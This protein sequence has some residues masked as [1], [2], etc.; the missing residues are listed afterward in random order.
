MYAKILHVSTKDLRICAKNPT[1]DYN[2]KL[3]LSNSGCFAPCAKT[4]GME[5]VYTW[6]SVEFG[7]EIVLRNS[8][9][10]V[11]NIIFA[12]KIMINE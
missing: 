5:Y 9:M 10:G 1:N 7:S 3:K 6:D 4:P 11:K 12:F 2:T 8:S